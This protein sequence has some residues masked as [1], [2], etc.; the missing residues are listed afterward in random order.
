MD[1]S[2]LL[3]ARGNGFMSHALLVDVIPKYTGKNL[4]HLHRGTATSVEQRMLET[5]VR[6]T[7]KC[8]AR[9]GCFNRSAHV[10]ADTGAH[11][12]FLESL[13]SGNTSCDLTA[14]K[15]GHEV[16]RPQ[17]CSS[18]GGRVCSPLKA[19]SSRADLE[20]HAGPSRGTGRATETRWWGQGARNGEHRNLGVRQGLKMGRCHD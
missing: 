15:C 19:G 2:S 1:S 9:K 16:Q 5:W 4:T 13:L 6:W 12:Y 17:K 3:D 20:T 14:Q 18:P 7:T 11:L 8:G 10:W